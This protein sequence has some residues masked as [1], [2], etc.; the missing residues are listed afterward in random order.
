MI[1]V[2]TGTDDAL[3]RWLTEIGDPSIEYKRINRG[4]L[5]LG[6][7]RN[8]AV[9]AAVGE[10]I[11]TWDDDDLYHPMRIEGQ[12]TGLLQAH[13]V[14][15]ILLRLVIWHPIRRRFVV[16]S[17]RPWEGSL[18]A[19]S[20]F[21]PSYIAGNR[22]EDTPMISALQKTACIAYLDAPELYV[23]VRHQRNTWGEDH[24]EEIERTATASFAAMEYG[25]VLAAFRGAVP[26]DE[27]LEA[28]GLA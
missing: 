15:S 12:M 23:Y 10:Y 13:A 18:L 4:R 27:Y 7:V 25:A 22:A 2:D 8:I 1:I 28:I 19:K 21:A 16:S 6:D 5:T 11:C 17:R 14:G 9:E 24:F 3:A 26:V 20:S